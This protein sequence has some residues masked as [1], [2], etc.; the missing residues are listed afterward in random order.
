MTLIEQLTEIFK[1]ALTRV[2]ELEATKNPW[3]LRQTIFGCRVRAF[4]GIALAFHYA[5]KELV[6]LLAL[7]I[8][9]HRAEKHNDNKEKTI[10]TLS[11]SL[12]MS[13]SEVK[14]SAF[15]SQ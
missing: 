10:T 4:I 5:R 1:K 11:R 9:K 6:K 15:W 14:A 7:A 8:A 3:Y 12:N 2:F 13:V